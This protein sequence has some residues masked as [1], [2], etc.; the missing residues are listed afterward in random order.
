MNDN[1]LVIAYWP[2][3]MFPTL[4][5]LFILKEK[6]KQ[7]IYINIKS[8]NAVSEIKTGHNQ[9]LLSENPNNVGKLE[10]R[11]CLS[12]LYAKL[13]DVYPRLTEIQKI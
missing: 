6:S 10:I 11:F 4:T 1:V 12:Q 13:S 2:Q 7:N 5:P 8:D 9:M 3:Y